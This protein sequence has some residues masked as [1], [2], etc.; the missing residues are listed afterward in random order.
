VRERPQVA[1]HLLARGARADLLLA[2]ALG[3]VEL[4]RRLLDEDPGRIAMSVDERWL[5]KRDPRAG[6]SI[7]NW[8]LERNHSAHFIARRFGHEQVLRLLLER[9]PAA[10]SLAVAGELGD[11]AT[12]AALADEHPGLVAELTSDQRRRL[13][14][15]AQDADSAAVSAML[16]AGWPVDARGQHGATAL[17]WAA[18]HGEAGMV[19]EIL[20]HSP[21]LE[22]RDHDFR[23]TP[24]GWALYGSKHGW[25]CRDGDYAGAVGALLAAGAQPPAGDVD[26]S[27]AAIEAL[28][29]GRSQA[30]SIMRTL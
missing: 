18:F 24:L 1:R 16:G 22:L 26:A 27:P 29:R 9:S 17:H 3:E 28:R 15:A 6:G 11:R 4:V 25:R 20:R 23:S 12:L 30:G 2:V 10:L 14:D 21:P 8:T 5:P 19:R 7:Y 13:V